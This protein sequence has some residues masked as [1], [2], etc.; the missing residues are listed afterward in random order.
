MPL[1]GFGDI[2]FNKGETARK[3]PLADLVDNKFKTNLLRY[4]LDVGSADKGHYM[5]FYIRQQKNTSFAT[6]TVSETELASAAKSAQSK[7]AAT[8]S[9]LNSNSPNTLNTKIG[10]ELL[11]K[12]NNGIGQINNATGG[13]LGNLSSAVGKITG[14]I[15]S[16]VESLFGQKTS[17]I[18]GNSAATQTRID[19]SIKSIVSNSIFPKTTQL[20]SDS[21]ALYMPDTLS[22][23]YSQSYDTPSLGG[24][25]T[26]QAV[27]AG[28]ALLEK[29]KE[30]DLSGAAGGLAKAAA[31]GVVKSMVDKFGGATGQVAFT[32]I[33]GAVSNPLLEMIY[34]SPNFRTFQFDFT[35]YPRDEREAL[36]VQQIIEKFRFHQAPE[37]ASAANFLIPPSEFDIKFYYGGGENPNIPSIAT[38]VLENIDVNYTPNGFSA[39]EVPGENLPSLGRTGMPVAIQMTMQFKETTYLTKSNFKSNGTENKK[40]IKG[41]GQTFD[42]PAA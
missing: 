7:N 31:G 10:G 16:S 9:Q 42:N 24:E 13:A 25:A 41:L 2:Q 18:G 4:P 6:T 27:A 5:V 37:I 14:G 1:F 22:Y 21:I 26:G 3:G 40:E 29:I 19:T 28:G 30:G 38:C 17:L 32:A 8:L 15:A 12:V 34:K 23:Q 20:T 33:T 39:Y 36:E 11:N 35:F